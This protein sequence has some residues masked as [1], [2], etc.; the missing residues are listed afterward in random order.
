LLQLRYNTIVFSGW[1]EEDHENRL[2]DVWT[3]I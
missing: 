1:S 2:V 3:E